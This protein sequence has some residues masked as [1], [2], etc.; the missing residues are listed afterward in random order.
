MADKIRNMEQSHAME[1]RLWDLAREDYVNL[2]VSI[3]DVLGNGSPDETTIND[4][5]DLIINARES[6]MMM[7]TDD[8]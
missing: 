7:R 8:K 5:E 2:L 6:G 1:N 3:E 4:I